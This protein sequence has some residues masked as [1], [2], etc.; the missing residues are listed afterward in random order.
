MLKQWLYQGFIIFV[1]ALPIALLP[2]VVSAE[3]Q[4]LKRG[5]RHGGLLGGVIG[6]AANVGSA[7][8][9]TMTELTGYLKD[10]FDA[11]DAGDVDTIER[12]DKKLEKLPGKLALKAIPGSGLVEGV[13][14][15]SE[16]VKEKLA[17]GWQSAT[18]K[19]D[20]FFDSGNDETMS[21]PRMALSVD[22]DKHEWHASEGGIFDD[23]PLQEVTLRK[24]EELPFAEQPVAEVTPADVENPWSEVPGNVNN[25]GW[26]VSEEAIE[27]ADPW[28]NEYD[29]TEDASQYAKESDPPA[30]SDEEWQVI[31]EVTEED[32][33]WEEL[34]VTEEDGPWEE[35][36]VTEEDGPWEELYGDSEDITDVEEYAEES[37]QPA[38]L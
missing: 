17:E 22:E 37:D 12:I 33:P 31:E 28:G 16:N 25:D 1:F 15:A 35:L 21:D 7:V 10:S 20:R 24:Y 9:E 13:L 30:D 32:G 34:E 18:E 3:S 38:D 4:W 8:K 29:D 14:D 2:A 5:T 19:I 23:A 11:F 26:N 36:E 6:H 27:D